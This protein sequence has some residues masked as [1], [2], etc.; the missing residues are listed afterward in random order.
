MQCTS[1]GNGDLVKDPVALW[2]M[3]DPAFLELDRYVC[4]YCFDFDFVPNYVEVH[5]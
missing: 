1:G 5:C 2:E 4:L 3:L